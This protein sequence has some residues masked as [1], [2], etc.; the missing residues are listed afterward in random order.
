MIFSKENELSFEFF[1]P[2]NNKEYTNLEETYK[3]LSEFNPT[4]VSYTDGAGA[5]K[6]RDIIKS[7]EILRKY[8]D[9]EVVAHITS[10]DKEKI[11]VDLLLSEYQENNITSF[12]VIRG[13]CPT[14]EF[15][16]DPDEIDFSGEN[17]FR[18]ASDLIK[19]LKDKGVS[20]I[21]FGAFPSGH[22][23]DKSFDQTVKT[24]KAKSDLGG[25]FSATQLFFDSKE[26]IRFHKIMKEE[27]SKVPIYAGIMPLLSLDQ[28]KR[29]AEI[30]DVELPKKLEEGFQKCESKEKERSFG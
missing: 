2:R 1:P 11:D 4:F 22:P 8:S 23:E 17:E 19:Y 18:H 24:F 9:T 7:V 15:L 21:G 27:D 26:Y 28:A 6:N 5:S 3:V 12:L 25:N 13:D 29:F 16:I 20:N 30:C 14:N 10:C